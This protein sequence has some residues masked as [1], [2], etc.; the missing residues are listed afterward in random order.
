MTFKLSN[1][2]NKQNGVFYILLVFCL[3]IYLLGLMYANDVTSDKIIQGSD[4]IEKFATVTLSSIDV[5]TKFSIRDIQDVYDKSGRVYYEVTFESK[6]PY[7]KVVCNIPKE[8]QSR[9][10]KD[11]LYDATLT[12]SYLS[13]YVTRYVDSN[14]IE[15]LD[16]DRILLALKQNKSMAKLTGVEF[17]YTEYI[18]SGVFTKDEALE[19][20]KT[21][22]DNKG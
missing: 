2:N 16:N 4:E 3:S 21:C 12:I 22:L 13:E 17:F 8:Y 1:G 7:Y 9:L 15:S 18:V 10:D 19:L 11:S 14:E 6:E 20:F 5:E